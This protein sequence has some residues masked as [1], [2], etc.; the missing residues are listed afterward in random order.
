MVFS[1][2]TMIE[3]REEDLTHLRTAGCSE[4][5]IN[6]CIAV[7]RKALEIADSLKIPVDIKLIRDGALNHDIGRAR[8][9]TILHA[10]AGA[11]IARDAGMDEKVVKII[12]RHIGAGIPAEETAALGLPFADYVPLSPEEVI[13]SYADN[14]LYGEKV[15]SFGESLGMLSKRLGEGHPGIERFMSMHAM[16]RSWME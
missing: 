2:E 11:E 1:M 16:V 3:I 8:T 12:E 7:A 13:V 14:L 5:V 9:Q 10:V 15:M 6:H 4:W